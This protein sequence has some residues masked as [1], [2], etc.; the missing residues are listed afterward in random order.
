MFLSEIL[1]YKFRPSL[2]ADIITKD[3]G[4]MIYITGDT[5][6]PIDIAKLN[7]YNFPMQKNL[8]K[9]DYVIICGDFGGVWDASEKRSI[10]LNN[11]HDCNFTTLFVDG[12]HENFNI[13]NSM[14]VS[15]WNGG[16]VHFVRDSIIHLMRGQIYTI[17]GMRF[18]TMGGGDS[19]DKYMRE[20]NITWWE[21]EMPS[22]E[23]YAEAQRNLE[24]AENDVDFIITHTA[25][26]SI[27]G[28]FHKS[29]EERPLNDFLQ[30]V[31][32]RISFKKWFFGHVHVNMEFEGKFISLYN[33]IYDLSGG[34]YLI[35]KNK[36]NS[37]DENCM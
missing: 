29:D 23:E 7:E 36:S 9:N 2:F 34:K 8:T 19:A 1:A 20:A 31:A 12:N 16:K 24:N 10:W 14:P 17:D 32:N 21:Q 15:Q 26:T 27:I 13:L 3:V 37:L 22:A 28:R 4:K 18:F 30:N 5:H 25:P 33:E 35:Q 11:L 6:I